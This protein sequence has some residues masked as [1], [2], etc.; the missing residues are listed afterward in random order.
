MDRRLQVLAVGVVVVAS[1]FATNTKADELSVWPQFRGNDANLVVMDQQIPEQFGPDTNCVWKIEIP[2]GSSSPV[3]WNDHLFLTGHDAGKLF[4]VCYRRSDGA[5]QWQREFPYDLEEDFFHAHCSP[6]ASTSCTDGKTVVSYFA[7]Y[8]MMAHDFEGNLL[9]K[10]EYAPERLAFGSGTSPILDGN[11]LY[12]VRDVPTASA[13]FCFDITTGKEIWMTPRPGTMGNFTTP[14]I[15]RH[16]DS[17]ELVVASAGRVDAY[18]C[19]TGTSRWTV[20]DTPLFVCPSPVAANDL[21]VVGAWTTAHATGD[22][23]KNSGFDESLEMTEEQK[24]DPDAFL[25]RFD[26]NKDGMIAP[27]EL[28][29]SRARDAFRFLDLNN[30]KKLE[31]PEVVAMFED[32]PAPGRN[33]MVAIRAGGQGD[34]TKTHVAWESTRNLPYVA[35]PIVYEDHVYYVKK[36]GLLTRLN[37]RDGGDGMTKRLDVGGEYYATPLVVDGKML[38]AAERGTVLVID[39]S[40]KM[41]VLAKNQLGESIA[42]TPAVVDNTLYVRTDKHLFAFGDR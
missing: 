5:L 21:L 17:V 11:R 9:W 37:L 42:A 35:S 4:V 19:Q 34:I 14:V 30:S 20:K 12:L 8:G 33:V 36:G 1:V 10:K 18:D 2:A 26:A 32:K 24:T 3:I 27:D 38:I 29:E 28:P 6:A 16:D 40:D 23:R 22:E 7:N 39:P 15:W 31:R 13:A 41:K 25:Q